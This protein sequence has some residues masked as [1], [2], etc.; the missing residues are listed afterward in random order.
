MANN[1]NTIC[2]LMITELCYICPTIVQ[3][4]RMLSILSQWQSPVWLSLIAS[5]EV[6]LCKMCSRATK[7]TCIDVYYSKLIDKVLFILSLVSSWV[8]GYPILAGR[9][10]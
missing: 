10:L 9:Y 6:R 3:Q 8:L 4:L 2:N 5:D 7:R 1:A